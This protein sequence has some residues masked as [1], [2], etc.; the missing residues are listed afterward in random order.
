MNESE[1]AAYLDRR[2]PASERG[3]IEG[4]LAECQDCRV[5]VIQSEQLMRRLGQPRRLLMGSGLVATAAALTLVLWPGAPAGKTTLRDGATSSTLV[6]YG[7]TGE[8]EPQGLRFVWADAPGVTTY[9]L[10]VSDEAGAPVWSGSVAD[11]VGSLPDSV[12]LR[13]DRGYFWVVDA[14]LAD[15]TIH[16]TGLREFHILR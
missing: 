8:V 6:A 4:H 13:R 5:E 2:L 1:V 11:T 12:T 15:G 7:P 10:I 9:R 16:S 14:L 3:R